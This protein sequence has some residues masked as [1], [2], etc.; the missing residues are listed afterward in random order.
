MLADATS[1]PENGIAGCER[2]H[3]CINGDGRGVDDLGTAAGSDRSFSIRGD[4][5][6]GQYDRAAVAADRLRPGVDQRRA[7]SS[8]ELRTVPGSVSSTVS[9]SAHRTLR[10]RLLLERPHERLLHVELVE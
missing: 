4:L 7:R 2:L 6:L 10:S 3:H 8:R 1:S 9:T 5:S